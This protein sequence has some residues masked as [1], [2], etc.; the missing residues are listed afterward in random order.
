MARV[1]SPVT[2]IVALDFPTLDAALG[3]V[4]EL[5]DLCRFYKVGSEL[6]TAAGP[7]IV[8]E[9]ERR[10]AATFLDLK[11]HDIPNTVRG[12]AR[13]A[14]ALGARLLTIHASGGRA[15]LDAA[16]AGAREGGTR[17]TAGTA[18][19]CEL[20]AVTVLTSLDAGQLARAWGREVGTIEA[21]VLRLAQLAAES[22]VDGIVC[23]GQEASAVRSRFGDQLAIL[24]PGVRLAGGARQD[25]ARVVTP[26]QAAASGARYIVVG[27]AVTGAPLPRRAMEEVLA[28]LS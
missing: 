11:L 4:D 10:G 26:R 25:Q 23:S 21:E 16:V 13:S 5:G 20:L 9:L 27:R 18:D 24:V 22:G 15:M 8:A 28:D 3:M 7:P 2:A 12:A 1:S 14:A 17:A 19:G 6:F